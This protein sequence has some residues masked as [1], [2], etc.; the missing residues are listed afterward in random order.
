MCRL[1][2]YW[3]DFGLVGNQTEEESVENVHGSKHI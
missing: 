1:I 3:F 2:V